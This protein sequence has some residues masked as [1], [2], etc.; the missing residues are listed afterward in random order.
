M[1]STSSLQ[2][3]A[4]CLVTFAVANIGRCAQVDISGPAGSAAFGWQVVGLPN[5]NIVVTDPQWSSSTGAVYLYTAEGALISTLTGSQAND[6]V[7]QGITV[8]PSGNFVVSSPNWAN[9]AATYAG[10]VTLVDGASGLSGHI[11]ADNS[12]VGT[13]HGSSVG[14]WGITVLSNGNYVVGSP[15][16]GSETTAEIGAVTFVNGH[17]GLTG[18]V[19]A[20]NSLIGTTPQ[21]FIGLSVVA[22]T[23][24][25]YVVANPIWSAGS[26]AVTWANGTT[27][28]SGPVSA[29]NSLIGSTYDGIGSGITPLTNGNYVVLSPSWHANAGA[30]TWC[31]GTQ[32]TVGS[33]SIVNSL[34]GQSPN[35]NIG[36]GGVVELTNGNFV[37][38]SGNWL[39]DGAQGAATWVN[40]KTGL[41]GEVTSA[42]SLYVTT[43][44]SVVA[45]TNGNY[46]VTSPSWA[47]GTHLNAGAVTWGDGTVGV[48]GTISPSNSL[49]GQTADDAVGS[50]VVALSNGNYVVA[51]PAWSNGSSKQH[52]GAITWGDGASGSVVGPVG[53]AI[54]LIG[55]TANDNVG[56]GGVTAL[57]NGNYVVASPQWSDAGIAQVGAV[58]WG[59]GAS[60][61]AGP[62]TPANSLTGTNANDK[63]GLSSSGNGVAALGNGNYVVSSMNWSGIGAATW[64][65]GAEGLTG[66]VS[67]SNSFV[68]TS[69]GDQ[70][71]YSVTPLPNGNYVI[72]SPNWS[73]GTAAQVGAVTWAD[74]TAGLIGAASI[75]NSLIGTTPGDQIGGGQ[76]TI[77]EP[78]C[79]LCHYN[80][81]SGGVAPLGNDYLVTSLLSANGAL[82]AAGEATLVNANGG[83]YG[84]VSAENSVLGAAADDG[85]YFL[86][87]FAYNAQDDRLIFGQSYV[88]RVSIFRGAIVSSV[89]LDQHGLTGSWFNPDTNGQGFEIETYPDLNGLGKG[90][91]FAGWFTYDVTAAG[92]R[93]WYAAFGEVGNGNPVGSLEI[94]EVDGG[95]LNAPPAINSHKI[96][97]A[98]AQFGDCDHGSFTYQFDDGRRGT[99]PLE[100]LSPNVTCTNTGDSAQDPANYPL[101]GNWSD[102]NTS[103]QGFMFDFNPRGYVF[104]AWYTFK[105]Q[106]QQLNG[107]AGQDW[108]TLYAEGL[109]AGA[110]SID[111]VAIYENSGGIFDS[112]PATTS[113]QVGT[114]A[115]TLLDCNS[116]TLTY[117]FTA[118]EDKGQQGTIHLQRTGPVP[119]GC[120]L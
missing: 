39:G 91:F 80:I 16:W 83:A 12:L 7:G 108:Y 34:L 48:S 92:G 97:I 118:G 65:D 85:L 54:A 94:D 3:A 112:P 117:T 43:P 105:P 110:T 115:L 70:I 4:F 15:F 58:T 14:S 10:A 51:S 36:S 55:N 1:L 31:D 13:T 98:T 99:I 57:S 59:N 119:A 86:G 109:G 107:A 88:N 67:L 68:G 6:Y 90:F 74:G 64:A 38:L 45:L 66:P 27:G 100:R 76:V 84:A 72:V 104:A 33:V 9:G 29:S 87:N 23:N 52:V 116:M 53:A 62:V 50:N 40:G 102:P 103:G 2:R 11:S 73:N 82:A 95:N 81:Y 69:P 47:N 41:A 75:A 30:T 60:G 26:G 17:T 89:N 79:P 56:S 42:N 35:D 77:L 8:L 114:A 46:V 113:I 25:N 120:H 37:V 28:L 21:D 19:S 24:G 32:P 44:V 106:G 96:G 71:G 18:A 111:N 93:R 61:I 5:G 101:S 22:L 78:P 63:V 20:D 49:V